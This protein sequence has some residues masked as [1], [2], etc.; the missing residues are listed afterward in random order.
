MIPSWIGATVGDPDGLRV[1]VV[2]DVYFDSAASRPAWLLVNLVASGE[3]FALVPVAGA[4]TSCDAITVRYERDLIRAS[5]QIARPPA[6]LTGEP[7]CRLA[8]HY[9]AR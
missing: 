9:G 2:C 6:V 1:G 7:A 3:R 5:P 4:R 8:Q